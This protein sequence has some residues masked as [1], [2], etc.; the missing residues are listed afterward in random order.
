MGKKRG[1][2]VKKFIENISKWR[3]ILPIPV[4]QEE[5]LSKI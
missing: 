1:F 4:E 2:R 5:A 3:R